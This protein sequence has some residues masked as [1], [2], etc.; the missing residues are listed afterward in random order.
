MHEYFKSSTFQQVINPVL[1]IR[2]DNV[3]PIKNTY[4]TTET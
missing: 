4:D 1:N 2:P 3:V